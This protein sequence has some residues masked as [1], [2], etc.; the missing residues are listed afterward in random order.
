KICD[1]VSVLRDGNYISTQDI[2]S[3]SRDKLIADMVGRELRE[4]YPRSDATYNE[5]V[6]EDK[7]ISNDTLKNISFNVYKG[8]ILGL[9]GLVG[10]G[11]TDLVRAIFGADKISNGIIKMNG[12]EINVKSPADALKNNIALLPED[13]KTQ[14]AVMRMNIKWNI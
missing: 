8:E 3:T 6:L 5:V 4:K 10:A 9:G 7:H 14:G 2:C 1:R 11:R 13:R 12:K